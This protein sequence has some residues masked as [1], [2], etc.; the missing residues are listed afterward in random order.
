MMSL[1]LSWSATLP[2][3]FSSLTVMVALVLSLFKASTSLPKD[4]HTAASTTDTA[5]TSTIYIIEL[6]TGE[7]LFFLRRGG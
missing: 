6:E 7:R 5:H 4:Q 1:P 3:S 2:K